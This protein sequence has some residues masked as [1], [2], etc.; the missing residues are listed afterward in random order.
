VMQKHM[1]V[2]VKIFDFDRAVLPNQT[3]PTILRILGMWGG[4]YDLSFTQLVPANDLALS[5]SRFI[6]QIQDH[7]ASN[8]SVFEDR[9]KQNGS[10]WYIY[11]HI[12]KH[13]SN[14]NTKYPPFK[15]QVRKYEGELNVIK[16]II[17]ETQTL[18]E[19]Y[20]NS[21]EWNSLFPRII[22]PHVIPSQE[23]VVESSR[24][25]P[26]PKKIIRET[27]VRKR[28]TRPDV[29]IIPQTR[30]VYNNRQPTPD[31]PQLAKKSS[32]RPLTPDPSLQMVKRTKVGSSTVFRP[33]AYETSRS[34]QN[35]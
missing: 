28:S 2:R 24:M 7:V 3:T 10:L 11:D 30:V 29:G 32:P 16:C 22:R 8:A 15:Y 6:T 4:T 5:T 27:P 18:V 12:N 33:R 19:A 26:S 23:D 13:K 20:N 35:P 25:T 31:L 14:W 1:P 9:L 34:P 17:K 21:R